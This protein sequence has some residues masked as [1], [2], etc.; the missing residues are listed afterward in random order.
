L[1][2]INPGLVVTSITPFGS[3][4]PYKDFEATELVVQALSG[5]MSGIGRPE[6]EPLEIG[7]P[8]SMFFAGLSAAAG[9]LLANYHEQ[10][11]GVGQLVEICMMESFLTSTNVARIVPAEFGGAITKRQYGGIPGPVK[12]K[13]GYIGL[14]ALTHAH[15]ETLAGWLGAPELLESPIFT[16]LAARMQH[17]AEIRAIFG[18]KVKDREKEE[19]FREGQSLRLPVAPVANVEDILGYDHLQERDFFIQVEHPV[20]GKVTQPGRPFLMSD[21]PWAIETPAP[22]LGEANDPVYSGLLSYSQQDMVKLRQQGV[23]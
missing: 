1:E 12:C 19:L 10:M 11:T 3:Y 16:D 18:E 9:T 22:L 15:W 8:L 2:R 21:T 6:K 5:V 7:V 17:G 20:L 4:G 23:I 14:N 13:D